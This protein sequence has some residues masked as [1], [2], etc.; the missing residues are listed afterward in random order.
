MSY[1]G[2]AQNGQWS[3]YEFLQSLASK[4]NSAQSAEQFAEYVAMELTRQLREFESSYT[5]VG[6]GIHFTAYEYLEGYW[7]PEVFIISNW[8]DS[9][10]THVFDTGLL[11][12]R[13]TYHAVANVDSQA[14]HREREFRMVVKSYLMNGGLIF[15][16]NGDPTMFN[17]SAYAILD[18]IRT[19]SQRRSLIDLSAHTLCA[20]A[21][22]PI[23]VVSNVQRSFYKKGSALVGGK[24]H[25]LVITPNGDYHSTTGDS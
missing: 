15:F 5:S 13:K 3:M 11:V 10:Y 19:A 12:E 21:R 18:M 20:I 16:N 17:P 24:P 7:I 14:V 22:L 8:T 4:A 25:D 9:L 2:L 1:W 6:V 23:E